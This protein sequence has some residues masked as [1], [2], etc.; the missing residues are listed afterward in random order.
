VVDALV[1]SSLAS[2]KREARQFID[3][4]A[5]TLNGQKVSDRKLEPTDFKEGV[6]LLKRGK[7]NVCVLM[8]S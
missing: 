6:A 2:S 3:D 1:Q 5:V 4:G 7:R 8:L